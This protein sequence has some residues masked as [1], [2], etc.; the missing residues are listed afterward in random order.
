MILKVVLWQAENAVIYTIKYCAVR[1]KRIPL[2]LIQFFDQERRPTIP[3]D[4]NLRV[5]RLS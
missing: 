2:Y 5:R 4:L 1:S 3:D